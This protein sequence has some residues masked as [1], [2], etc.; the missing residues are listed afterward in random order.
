M[1]PEEGGGKAR[2][3]VPEVWGARVPHSS[4]QGAPSSSS[5]AGQV[6]PQ[7]H[8]HRWGRGYLGPQGAREGRRTFF[9]FSSLNPH[10]LP[11]VLP[12][13]ISTTSDFPLHLSLFLRLFKR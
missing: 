10:S 8:L 1:T 5:P 3:W 13:E 11:D 12:L 7:R 2:H 4:Q 9:C 6:L